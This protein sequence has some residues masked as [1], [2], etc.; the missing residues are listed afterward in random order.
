MRR[1]IRRVRADPAAD[2]GWPRL[3]PA[4][5]RADPDAGR[6]AGVR[7]LCWKH[8]EADMASRHKLSALLGL[9]LVVGCSAADTDKAGGGRRPPT[10]TLTLANGL[11]G[12]E[13]LTGFIQEVARL[14]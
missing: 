9:V 13:E 7:H 4:A 11:R 8:W 10:L 12:P 3:V 1:P 5:V 14:S 2:R 6:P